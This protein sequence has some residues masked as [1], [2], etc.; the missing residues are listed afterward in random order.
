M[1]FTP[2]SRRRSIR[3]V[4]FPLDLSEL[5][6][7]MENWTWPASSLESRERHKHSSSPA[8]EAVAVSFAASELLS[9]VSW[10]P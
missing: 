4:S 7:E 3:K 8:V 6:P 5:Q 9:T 2:R 1:P 10:L